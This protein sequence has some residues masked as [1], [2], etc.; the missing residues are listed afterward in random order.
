M[1]THS[2]TYSSVANRSYKERVLQLSNKLETFMKSIKDD[3]SGV[4]SQGGNKRNQIQEKKINDLD[5]QILKWHE[6]NNTQFDSI[7]EK[8]TKIFKNIAQIKN[9]REAELAE[10]KNQDNSSP[11]MSVSDSHTS[12]STLSGPSVMCRRILDLLDKQSDD[13]RETENKLMGLLDEKATK[14]RGEIAQESKARFESIDSLKYTD[15]FAHDYTQF[16]EVDNEIMKRIEDETSRF[17]ESLDDQKASLAETEKAMNE[18][19]VDM[20][21]K[22][23]K[24]IEDE[25]KIREENEEM[26]LGLLENTCDKLTPQEE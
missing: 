24:E 25:K 1:N 6:N 15:H 16:D 2:Q 4:G 5:D 14:L 13:R 23:Q 17:D 10:L 20:S 9:E 8:L 22:I 3:G 26:L 19:I 21:S 11:E 18:I 12:I 7:Q